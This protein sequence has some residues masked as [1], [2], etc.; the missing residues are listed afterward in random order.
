MQIMAGIEVLDDDIETAALADVLP[1]DLAH[2]VAAPLT[3]FGLLTPEDL[4]E[5]AANVGG[6]WYRQLQ[7]LSREDAVALIDWM[8]SAVPGLGEI[9]AR[10]YPPGEAPESLKTREPASDCAL[11]VRP[12]E[13]MQLAGDLSGRLGTN[14]VGRGGMLEA[15]NDL[16]AVNQWLAARAVNPNTRAQ[17]R[18]EAERFIL[19]CTLERGLALSSITAKDAALFP[20]W[21]EGL[22]RTDPAVWQQLWKE[23]QE[24]WIGPKN[25]ARTSPAWRPYNG[26]LTAT[27]RKTSLTVIRLLFSFLVK[28]G[29]L[30]YNPFDQVSGKVRLLPGEGAPRD[31]ADR[32][33][34]ES[35]W[36]DVL[37]YLDSLPE[38]LASARIRVV[39]CLGK[40]LGMR[41]SEIIHAQAGW[42]V[43]RRI[44]DDD[45]LVI[46]IVGK[47]DKVRRLPVS[48]EALDAINLYFSLRDLPPVLKAD[49]KTALVASLG[50]GRKK[51]PASLTAIS[52]SGLYR[53]L[54]NFFEGAALAAEDKSPADA[55]KLRAAST[56]W[57]RHTFASCALRTMD[58]NVVQNAMG[59]ASIGTTSRY[60]TPED[61]QIAKAMKNMSPI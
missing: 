58:I 28:T 14:R 26:P 5:C 3:E 2:R 61:A 51:D 25:A 53:A 16:E 21:L 10:F 45:L 56:H 11:A 48:S 59:H 34:S 46:E 40:G 20:R 52:R 7:G 27:S 30:Q 35:Q 6:N 24:L 8:K 50:I 32:S 9:T 39:L 41:A 29:Y 31:F 57:L 33:L 22:G 55:A 23:P 43:T 1:A 19:W 47:G 38:N 44:G 37:E 42:L 60:L 18:K 49:P 13:E 17:Y 54:E 12:M 15:G 4:Y 36:E